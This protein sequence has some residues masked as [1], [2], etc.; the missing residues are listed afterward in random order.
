VL[1]RSL[2]EEIRG[3]QPRVGGRKLFF[4]LQGPFLMHGLKIGRDKFFE[5]LGQE[6]LLIL[7]SHKRVYTTQSHHWLHK[8]PYLCRNWA[9]SVA[10]QLWVSDI[11]Y[12]RAAS[13]F[14]YLILIVDAYSRCIMGWQL[15]PTLEAAFCV[16]ALKQA[17]AARQYPERNLMHHSDRGV[18]YCSEA[19]TTLLKQNDIQISMTQDGSPYDNAQAER[20][21]GILKSEFLLDQSFE[22]LRTAREKVA[23]CI[24]VYNEKRPHASCDYLTPLQAHQHRGELQKRW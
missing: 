24:H 11:T 8:Y 9:P 21:N 17:L 18:Q 10:E 22:D 14:V 13:R 16:E 6:E 2:V 3:D 19:Y 5:F 15:S 12:L 23:K 4:L 1:L 20:I 7:T